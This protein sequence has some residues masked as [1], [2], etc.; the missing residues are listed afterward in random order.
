M[1]YFNTH[2]PVNTDEH[3]V[4][5]RQWLVER[6]STQIDQGKYFTIFAPRQMGKT[7]LLRK[8]EEMLDANSDYLPIS[9][10][11]ERF[12][13][14]SAI[15]F[16]EEFSDSIGYHIS[17][18][19][20]AN[21]HP[22]L[23][24][25]QTLIETHP[26]KTTLA[27]RRFFMRFHQIIPEL[28]IILILDEFDATPKE[29]LSPLLKTWR[30][31]YLEPTPP[32]CL[33]SVILIGIQNIAKLNFGRSSPFNIAYQLRLNGFLS[34]E[35][36][37][38]IGQYTSESGQQFE[39][40]AIDVLY[41]QTAGHP[42]LVNRTAAIVTEELVTDR[43]TCITAIHIRK[44]LQQLTRETN[45]NFETII[46]HASEYR[47]DVMDILL[48]GSYK[49]NLNNELVKD[50]YQ[51]GVI[52]EDPYQNCKIANSVYS[53]VLLA[54]FRPARVEF[55]A[56]VLMNG[57]DFRSHAIDGELQIDKLL[58]RFREFVERRGQEAFKVTDAPQEATGQ[59]MLMAYMDIIVRQLGGDIFTEVDS[60]NGRIDLLI[61]YQGH[62]YVIE[63]K[64]WRGPIAFDNGLEQ[65]AR[66]LATEGVERGYYVI[67]HARP[68][69]Y[70][71][72]SFEELEFETVQDGKQIQV[73]LV[74]LE[75]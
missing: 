17:Q 36:E 28:K 9:L 6:H 1:R 45:Y 46:R 57:Y 75:L 62:R 35:V 73:Y 52:R 34:E 14:S 24:E 4:V 56:Q 49:F 43:T 11:F 2:G 50:L 63:T 40:E 67:F 55:Q 18:T 53:E 41:E 20:K 60:G 16:M 48:G 26:P 8:L 70:G 33:H 12:E 58:S 64:I 21:G 22:K 3:Y 54:A 68:N 10:T 30:S 38:L 59:Y 32:H 5:S 51:Q 19:L 65:L 44:A 69:V 27:F 15:D 25:A 29:S 71:K 7:T 42:F 72:L 31:M 66:Y 39:P 61:V 23:E 37:N 74:R 13:E 47:E